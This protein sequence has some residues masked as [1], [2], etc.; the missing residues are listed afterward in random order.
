LHLLIEFW[1]WISASNSAFFT[2]VLISAYQCR[3]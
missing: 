2:C 1:V 3:R